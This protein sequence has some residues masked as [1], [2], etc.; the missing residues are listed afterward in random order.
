MAMQER[1]FE[2][3]NVG[4]FEDLIDFHPSPI[5]EGPSSDLAR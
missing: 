4:Q 1:Q 2:M 5:E 3:P